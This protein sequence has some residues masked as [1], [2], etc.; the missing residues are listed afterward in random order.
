MSNRRTGIAF[1]LAYV[2]FASHSVAQTAPSPPPAPELPGTTLSVPP[3][4]I[5][6]AQ[7]I[8]ARTAIQRAL[9]TSP[10]LTASRLGAEQAQEDVHAEEGRYP[11]VFQAD[12][13]YLRT[14]SPRVGADDSVRTSTSHSITVG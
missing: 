2:T 4:S 6:T 12:A 8:D 11:F 5:E 9:G 7:P 14:A 3:P 1:V 10:S 13:G